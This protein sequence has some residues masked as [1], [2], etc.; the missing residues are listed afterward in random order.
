VNRQP[1]ILIYSPNDVEMYPNILRDSGY[2][3]MLWLASTPE[4]AEEQQHKTR[5]LRI[6]SLHKF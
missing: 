4:E 5:K 3:L 6:Y 1:K 2:I